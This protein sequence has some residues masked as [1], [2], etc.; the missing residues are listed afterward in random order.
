MRIRM[1]LPEWAYLAATQKLSAAWGGSNPNALVHV[2]NV[3]G[4]CSTRTVTSN[5]RGARV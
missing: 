3:A 5:A 1:Q 4:M 2:V